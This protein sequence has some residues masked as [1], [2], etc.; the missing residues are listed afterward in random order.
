MFSLNETTLLSAL[1]SGN[2]FSI[3]NSTVYPS[4]GIYLKSGAKAV[5]PTSFLGIEY[6]ADAVSVSAPIEGGS[7][8]TYNKVKR[9]ALIRVVFTL[10]G[11]TGFSGGIPNITN[12]SLTSRSDLLSSLDRMVS[13]ADLYD[14]ETPDTTY[15]D[16]DLQ[17]Y[18]YRTSSQD[19]TLLTVEAIFQAVMQE[20]EVGIANTTAKSQPAKNDTSRGGSVSSGNVNT[21]ASD[22]TID[23]VKGALAG[24]KSSLSSAATSVATS[25]STAVSSSTKG[26]TNAINSAAESSINDLSQSIDELVKGLS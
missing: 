19:V 17:R 24:L 25:V 12:F 22:A 6:G 2:I 26:I 18:N 11:W 10:E 16:Y 1:N 21:N 9:P 14:I 15:E 23:D 20:A 3:I 8:T 5:S 13:S 7:Y 4:Y